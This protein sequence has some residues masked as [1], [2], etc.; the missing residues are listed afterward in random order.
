MAIITDITKQKRNS[1]RYNIYIDYE[2]AFSLSGE[3]LIE[4]NLKKNSEID[5]EEITELVS[6]E[7][8]KKAYDMTLN[9][10]KYRMRSQKEI[11]EYLIRKG[12]DLDTIE[13]V[14]EKLGKY[15]FVNDELFAEAMTRDLLSTKLVGRRYIVHKLRQKGIDEGIIDSAVAQ[16]DD[17]AEFQRACQLA[18][19]QFNRCRE[20]PSIKDEQRIARL[21]ARRGF[22]WYM[23]NRIL[24]E[25]RQESED[26]I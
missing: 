20:A 5:E 21:M 16:I 11:E 7:N 15:D 26:N 25:K 13:E 6:K 1:E 10:L 2:Y 19:E 18:E 12:F 4:Y 14:L 22:E 17:E 9:Y 8:T 24:R 3:L 23:I